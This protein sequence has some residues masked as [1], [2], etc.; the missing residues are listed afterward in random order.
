ML[1]PSKRRRC[2][3]RAAMMRS[4]TRRDVL[5]MRRRDQLV[6]LDARHLHEHVH[7]GRA[8]AR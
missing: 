2:M 3:S 4:P 5:R 6:V 7:C 8:A 1:V